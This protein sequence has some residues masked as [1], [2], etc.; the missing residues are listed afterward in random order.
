[1]PE[2]CARGRTSRKNIAERPLDRR[3]YRGDYN[4]VGDD[5]ARRLR[6]VPSGQGQIFDDVTLF[7]IT[8]FDQYTRSTDNDTDF[9]PER[10]FELIQSDKAWQLWN[11]IK[12]SGELAFEPMQWN[13]GGYYLQRAPV[14][15]R[16][17]PARPGDTRSR[18]HRIYTQDIDSFGVWGEFAWDFAD[19]FTLDGG[20]RYN[21][22]KKKFDFRV[23][24]VNTRRFVDRERP[25]ATS[26]R[27]GRRRPAR[28]R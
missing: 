14:Q 13:I 22:E 3:P 8:S 23:I 25:Q 28:S 20:V 4:R 2:W 21:Y 11:E 19:D 1:M 16:P 17:A 9:T 10:L 18:L 15:Q 26:M 6:R 27:P 7:G 12:L 5:N 24:Q